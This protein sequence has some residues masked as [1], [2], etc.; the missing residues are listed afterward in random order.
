MPE[1]FIPFDASQAYQTSPMSQ[2]SVDPLADNLQL[3]TRRMISAH[4]IIDRAEEAYRRDPNVY[5]DRELEQFQA[6]SQQI[7]RRPFGDLGGEVVIDDALKGAVNSLLFNVPQI[8]A[9]SAGSNMFSP[10][11]SP[12]ERSA[13]R[14]GDIAGMVGGLF[15]GGYG[16][17]RLIGRLT[18][19]GMNRTLAGVMTAG[20]EGALGSALFSATDEKG[21]FTSPEAVGSAATVGAL[22]GAAFGGIAGRFVKPAEE[23]AQ[24]IFSRTVGRFKGGKNQ[25]GRYKKVMNSLDDDAEFERLMR[26]AETGNF[27]D[28]QDV[29]AQYKAIEKSGRIPTERQ[30]QLAET[31]GARLDESI[32]AGN[33]RFAETL[34]TN[35]AVSAVARRVDDAAAKQFAED[36]AFHGYSRGKVNGKEISKAAHQDDVFNMLA[37]MP[38]D[39]VMRFRRSINLR[40]EFDA[41]GPDDFRRRREIADEIRELEGPGARPTN[42]VK[43]IRDRVDAF[44]KKVPSDVRGGIAEVKPEVDRLRGKILQQIGSTR[45]LSEA[46]EIAHTRMLQSSD[47]ENRLARIVQKANSENRF[48]VIAA[49]EETI[50]GGDW[51]KA[52]Q[53]IT[54]AGK[55][56]SL[57]ELMQVLGKTANVAADA[58]SS[59]ATTAARTPTPSATVDNP[60]SG[61]PNT[62]IVS[63]G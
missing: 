19:R 36:V 17:A 62:E 10:G 53:A 20:G 11:D 38:E 59:A 52:L 50:E 63:P 51:Q 27:N 32:E 15:A 48:D 28:P 43:H 40:K 22:G 6:L 9:K 55:S 21:N 8:L 16:G 23:G 58:A 33:R 54:S 1:Q 44:R 3:G 2:Q 41:L 46:Q 26:K 30:T 57:D 60:F 39:E 14:V 25:G 24:G 61:I 49:L 4:R 5:S 13:Y 37:S 29:L 18:Q 12:A 7:R 42:L 34:Q 35:P 47:I 31:I 45:G 56:G